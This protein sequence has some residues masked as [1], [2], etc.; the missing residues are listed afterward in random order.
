MTAIYKRLSASCQQLVQDNL[1]NAS[2]PSIVVRS[3]L[4]DP[5][6]LPAIINHKC[7]NVVLTPSG[8]YFDMATTVA[9]YICENSAA[10]SSIGFNVCNMEAHKPLLVKDVSRVSEAWIEMETKVL[11]DSDAGDLHCTFH[12]VTATG[13]RLQTMGHCNVR[14][15]KPANWLSSW[16]HQ[17]PVIQDR[18][19]GLLTRAH[20]ESSGEVKLV[21]KSKAYKMFESFVQYSG[22]Y[23]NVVECTFDSKTLEATSLLD[24]G[25]LDPEK[26]LI[27]PYLLDG[28]C[29]VSGFVC[30]AVEQ[31]E[32]KNAFISNGVTAMRISE[33]LTPWKQGVEIRN[34]VRMEELVTDKTVLE[35]NVYVLQDGEIV[36]VWEGVRFKRIPRRVLDIFLPP[37]KK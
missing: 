3:C 27:G 6:L 7:N 37:G 25:A 17:T 18:I 29:H 1:A 5:S 23:Q 8:L 15:E 19:D 35:G 32:K 2:N 13:V 16:S 14:F 20:K 26:D 28:S 4:S 10:D 11:S 33:K 12:S 34:Y 9:K 36:G 30:N 22:Q 24:F 31:D 21:Q